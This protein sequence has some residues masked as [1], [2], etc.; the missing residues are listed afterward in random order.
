MTE[1]DSS[2][3]AYCAPG[4]KNYAARLL[5]DR[6]ERYREIIEHPWMY[7]RA[8]VIL[9]TDRSPAGIPLEFP[10]QAPPP[11]NVRVERADGTVIPCTVT[12]DDPPFDHAGNAAWIAVPDA[13]VRLRIGDS[14]RADI[15]PARTVLRFGGSQA[16]RR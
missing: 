7:G 4:L 12:R 8:D 10:G 16:G 5:E 3:V 13:A 6:G 15:L 14:V 2:V 1:P 11:E 9:A